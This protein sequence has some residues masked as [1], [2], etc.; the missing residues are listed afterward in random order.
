MLVKYKQSYEAR[1]HEDASTF[2]GHAYDAFPMLG[3][4]LEKAGAR[5]G[6]SSRRAGKDCRAWW[7]RPASSTSP[8]SDHG[9]LGMDAFEMQTVKNG[10]FVVYSDTA[11][12]K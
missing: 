8:P 2:G 1:Y 5:Q 11:A 6:E 12:K 10:K 3:K 7:A 9:G 4:A